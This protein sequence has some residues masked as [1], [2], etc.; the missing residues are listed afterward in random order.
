MKTS[1][2]MEFLVVLLLPIIAIALLYASTVYFESILNTFPSQE[3]LQ[4]TNNAHDL[5]VSK[6]I[7]LVSLDTIQKN[8]NHFIGIHYDYMMVLLGIILLNSISIISIFMYCKRQ[9]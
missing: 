8:N 3:L 5:A 4:K 7:A 9:V 1:V 6:E 2:K